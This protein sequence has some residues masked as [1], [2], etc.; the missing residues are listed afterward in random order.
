MVHLVNI[1]RDKLVAAAAGDP[2]LVNA[3]LQHG[4]PAQIDGL[5]QAFHSAGQAAAA[6]DDGFA[7]AR[8]RFERAWLRDNEEHPINDSSRVRLATTSLGVQAAQLPVIASDLEEIA[9]A[10]AEAQRSS[11]TCI[12]N[13]EKSLQHIDSDL[14]NFRD[15][16][17]TPQ[18][19][20]DERSRISL[21]IGGFEQDAVRDTTSTWQQIVHIRDGYTGTLHVVEGKLR[22]DG[23]D[24]A[25]VTTLDQ[26]PSPFPEQPA[27]PFPS[28]DT[29]AEIVNKWWTALSAEQKT[30]L[31]AQHSPDLGNLNGIPAD[32]RNE[33]NRAVL[34]DDLNRAG[35]LAMLHEVPVADV[36]NDPGWYGLTATDATRYTNA[37]RTEQGL[38]ASADAV[39]EHNQHPDVLLLR[40]EPAAFGGDGAA[41]I[42]MGNPDTAANT[43][44]LVKGLGSGVKQGTLTNPDGVRLY[45][46]ANRADWG[47]DTA[48]VMWVGYDAPDSAADPGLYEPNMARSG[49]RSLAADVNA[50]AVTH[51]GPTHVTVVGHSYG[52]TTVADA[53][54]GFGM[55]AN[56]IVLVGCPGTDLA[57]SAADFQLSPDGHLYVGDASQD[58]VSLFGED[59]IKTPFGGIGLGQDPA[60]DGYGSVRFK[61]EVPGYS[62]N[63]FYDHS[64]YFDLGSESLF[65]IGDV[66][67]GHGDAL[68]H[69]GMTARHRGEYGLPSFVDPEATRP[70]TKGHRHTAPAG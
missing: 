62:F 21:R 15:L 12:A 27:L 58:E 23:Y 49:G 63:P 46:E 65:S 10:L 32:V 37:R 56:D 64:H 38:A 54:A 28:P 53:A 25:L 22:T 55:H 3:T 18:L 1:D 36:L 26:P 7:R 31:I 48:V 44:V 50:F 35:D 47:K 51:Q 11:A 43:A 5:A 69:D 17:R 67:S 30:R 66:I 42:T 19:T 9:A 45:N 16:E 39:N 68:A 24:S 13:L 41:A 59:T 52:S 34:T 33:V 14:G 4:R 29:S 8:E 2:W 40:Y 6:A 20:V 70:A 60:L 61:A 57:R